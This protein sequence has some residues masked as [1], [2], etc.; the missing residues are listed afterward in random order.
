M[1]FYPQSISY[2]IRLTNR[3]LPGQ[4]WRLISSWGKS[5]GFEGN[6][7][8]PSKTKSKD[9][10]QKRPEWF[11]EHLKRSKESLERFEEIKRRIDSDPFGMIFGRRLEELYPW[12]HKS[13]AHSK[14]GE[15]DAK[16][17]DFS[18][19]IYKRSADEQ[20]V[21]QSVTGMNRE[22]TGSFQSKSFAHSSLASSARSGIG[23]DNGYD[24]DPITM[25]KVPREALVSSMSDKNITQ[26]ETIE[27]PVKRFVAATVTNCDSETPLKDSVVERP[28][29]KRPISSHE[30]TIPAS[31]SDNNS[32][33]WLAQEGFGAKSQATD[34]T[35]L[36]RE[37]QIVNTKIKPPT[38]KIESALDRHLRIQSSASQREATTPPKL[39]CNTKEN[40]TEHIDLLRPND[41]RAASGLR[42]R[43]PKE[44]TKEQEERRKS[45]SAD[46]E[47]RVQDL[48]RQFAEEI[49]SVGGSEKEI[50]SASDQLSMSKKRSGGSIAAVNPKNAEQTGDSAEGRHAVTAKM[51]TDS[52]D[53]LPQYVKDEASVIRGT[54]K[55]ESCKSSSAQD[56]G[57]QPVVSQWLEP[58]EGDMAHNVHEF[59]SRDRW[60]KQK[61]PHAIDQSEAK[62][63]QAAKDKAFICEIRG[64][65]EETYGT[66]D[67]KHRQASRIVSAENHDGRKAQSATDPDKQSQIRSGVS[68]LEANQ[69]S[70]KAENIGAG[71]VY[72][73]PN[74]EGMAMIQRLFEE[75]HETQTL[76]QAH[77]LEL[78]KIPI[79]GES[80]NLLQSLKASE[81][82]VLQT[83]KTAWGLLKTN[84]ALPDTRMDESSNKGHATDV[85]TSALRPSQTPISAPQDSTD[86]YRILAYDP[87]T[88]KITNTKTTSLKESTT[89]TP[90]TLSETLSK[91]NN[92]AKFV[93]YFT[94][95]SKLG[96]E[97]ISGGSDILVFKKVR[98]E[99]SP[100][101]T[102]DYAAATAE[103]TTMHANPIDGTTTQTGNFAS[104]TGFVNHDAVLPP[105]DSELQQPELSYSEQHSFGQ[106]V[107]REEAV[108]SGSSRTHWQ[109]HYN[110]GPRYGAK[111]KSRLRR[112]ARRKRTLRRMVW[113]GVWTASCCYG[114]GLLT[115]HL[116]A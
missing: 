72:N 11:A 110:Q 97:I 22:R 13:T 18:P 52:F 70:L 95:L 59:A 44:T 56:L 23:T 35:G 79:K 103:R 76:I 90:L 48:E 114:V 57:A 91:L 75:L 45:L 21:K 111:L 88:Q 69:V 27:I 46:Y 16:R 71:E 20:T 36:R 102:S 86:V 84:A 100:S 109:D 9:E 116:R 61:A 73:S 8:D 15:A 115:E 3:A 1:K 78:E 65:Y 82:R 54:H 17:P 60:Y 68:A 55:A 74:L 5:N 112:A 30:N 7:N 38:T 6:P 26:E 42:G 94:S 51:R 67:T 43:S 107:R 14:S 34:V 40:T 96:Y 31:Q 81:Q 101:L 39:Q 83:L 87:H 19:S 64:I 77:K 89:E 105:S 98:Q 25:R 108:F 99:K 32:N 29:D 4:S 50:D 24:I 62:V 12:K 66:I 58:G 10:E 33:D 85:A 80:N 28:S 37:P 47:N 41:V 113:V 2:P 92:P 106:K 93:P 53:A 104:P 49:A 63:L